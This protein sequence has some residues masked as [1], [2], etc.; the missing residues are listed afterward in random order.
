MDKSLHELKENLQKTQK[1]CKLFTKM[2]FIMIF[3]LFIEYIKGKGIPHVH[4]VSFIIIFIVRVVNENKARILKSEISVT[5]RL[6]RIEQKLTLHD[7]HM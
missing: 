1:D 6:E 3:I 4:I 7:R 2:I 5:E